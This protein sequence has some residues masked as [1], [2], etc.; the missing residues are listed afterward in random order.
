MKKTLIYTSLSVVAATLLTGCF[1]DNGT[2]ETP[3]TAVTKI[4]TDTVV[5]GLGYSCAGGATQLTNAA[6]EFTC[7]V[8]DVVTFS[9]GDIIL[10][11]LTASSKAA[12]VLSPYNLQTNNTTVVNIAQLIQSCDDDGTL[13]PTIKID[14]TKAALFDTSG[15]AI[16]SGTFDTY[17]NTLLTAAGYALV[18]NSSAETHL[19]ANAPDIIPPV[20]TLNGPAS[21]DVLQGTTYTD[22]GATATD[23][24]DG[25]ITPVKSGTVD[26]AVTGEYTIT[27][28]ATD[29]AGNT[30]TKT[31]TVTVTENPK[32]VVT[33]NGASTI[34]LNFGESYTDAGATATDVPDGNLTASIVTTG[35]VDISTPG[36]YTITYT[37]T[38]SFGSTATA[39]RTVIVPTDPKPVI[40]LNGASTV[41]LNLD[42]T[43]TEVGATATDVPDGDLTASIITTGTVDTSTPGT[44]TITYAVT[45]SF[46]ST[47]TATRMV[48][49]IDT[50]P[51]VVT[52]NG[53]ATVTQSFG[54]YVDA[55][56]TVTDNVDTGLT[57]I[58]NPVLDATSAAG[59][60]TVTYT[61]T[62]AAGN[63]G[64]ATRTVTINPCQNVNPITG[65][66]ED[67]PL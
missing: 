5:E 22:A 15:I 31:R 56:A 21:L 26:T 20:V 37:V 54:N 11:T 36:T 24:K 12:E 63:V 19:K 51:P 9:I 33:L 8:G 67:K 41:T 64:T 62:D 35:T 4:F 27:W 45:D 43:Y 7:N 61:A 55:G 60:Y 16:D 28:T 47:A 6:G 39:T 2:A 23:N 3:S 49:V 48:M 59:T 29:E 46:A 66:C 52:L 44:Y 50:I 42:D 30:D 40:T 65:G 34:T 25:V 18:S 1:G 14:P 57:V 10:G 17:A 38:D 53:S 32:P 58:A 13:T